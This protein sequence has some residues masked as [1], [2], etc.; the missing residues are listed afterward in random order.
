MSPGA[1]GARG[2]WK[3][4]LDDGCIICGNWAFLHYCVCVCVGGWV[5]KSH[6]GRV[7]FHSRAGAASTRPGGNGSAGVP[8]G[9]KES[10]LL[11]APHL[12]QL[13]SCRMRWRASATGD[14]GHF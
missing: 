6:Y 2:V 8:T 9:S 3:C 14:G 12:K 10:Q 1:A 7:M 11:P 5:V 4:S 13:H